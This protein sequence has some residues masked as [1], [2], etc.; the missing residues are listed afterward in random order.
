MTGY[1]AE[2]TIG[3]RIK[4]ARRARGFRTT[5]DLADAMP[6][7]KISEHVLENIE[8]G[9]KTDLQVSSLL[10]IAMALRVPPAFLLAP[11]THPARALDLPNLSNDVAAMTVVEFDAWLAGESDGAYRSS[12]PAERSDLAELDAFRELQRLRRELQRETVIGVVDDA[13]N[14]SVR[15]AYLESQTAELTEFLT[16]AGWLVDDSGAGS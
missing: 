12:D 1:S 10:S 16:K 11:L 5:R 7:S 2:A 4:A 6:G 9:R 8:A 3:D 13:S 15:R 14:P